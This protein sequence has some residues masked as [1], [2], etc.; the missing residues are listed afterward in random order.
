[1]NKQVDKYTVI[2]HFPLIDVVMRTKISS[3]SFY[4]FNECKKYLNKLS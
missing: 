2:Y 4:L 3:L 1:M